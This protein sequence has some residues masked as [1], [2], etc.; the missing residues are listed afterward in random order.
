M[1]KLYDKLMGCWFSF[2]NLL[3]DMFSA[4]NLL[5]GM[6]Y[7]THDHHVMMGIQFLLYVK[8]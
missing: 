6:M 4:F 2:N 3:F 1:K 7:A 5:V 8:K